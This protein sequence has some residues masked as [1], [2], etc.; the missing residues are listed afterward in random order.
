VAADLL[1]AFGQLADGFARRLA[2]GLGRAS[3]RFGDRLGVFRADFLEPV[4]DLEDLLGIRA[5]EPDVVVGQVVGRLAFEIGVHVLGLGQAFRILGL[6]GRFV[7]G[8]GRAVDR[9]F[10]VEAVLGVVAGSCVASPEHGVLRCSCG[11][12][13]P[14][15]GTPEINPLRARQ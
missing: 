15:T 14:L 6:V 1:V 4:E 12:A 9:G 7:L 13:R 8:F 2:V 5:V 3:P 11:A 10:L